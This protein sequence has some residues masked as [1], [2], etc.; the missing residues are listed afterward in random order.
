MS[1][2]YNA[3]NPQTLGNQELRPAVVKTFDLG[4]SQFTEHYAASINL[5]HSDTDDIVVAEPTGLGSQ[6]Q[7]QNGGSQRTTGAEL[8]LTLPLS[9]RATLRLNYQ[10][11]FSNRF[12]SQQELNTPSPTLFV[13]K[14]VG[15]LD[16]NYRLNRWNFNLSGFVHSG[17]PV[18][19][20]QD[21]VAVFDTKIQYHFSP[22]FTTYL[23]V[24]NLFDKDWDSPAPGT[25]LGAT[26]DGIIRATP[27]RDRWLYLGLKYQF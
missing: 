1:R 26:T 11:I 25:G 8:E 10:H 2:M 27:N 22:S 13:A 5:Y 21:T 7:Y 9:N 23:K 3:N 18:L 14:R 17:V 15:S 24:K 20:G 16:L 4:F 12:N 6:L 19:D